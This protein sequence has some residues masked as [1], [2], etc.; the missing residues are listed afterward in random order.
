MTR[1]HTEK[2]LVT[3]ADFTCDC[4]LLSSKNCLFVII[5]SSPI[6]RH[7]FLRRLSA[8]AKGQAGLAAVRMRAEIVSA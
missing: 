1:A 3:I 8:E 4:S 6:H 5:D 7:D 2:Y